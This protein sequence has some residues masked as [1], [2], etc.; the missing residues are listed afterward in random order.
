MG[1][2]HG[3]HG[4]CSSGEDM[5]IQEREVHR[6]G[7]DT[8]KNITKLCSTGQP[9]SPR[10][11]DD[12]IDDIEKGRFRYFVLKDNKKAYVEVVNGQ[13]GKFLRTNWDGTKRNNLEDLPD[14]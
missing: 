10:L 13:N 1:A 7:R 11:K 4:H 6:T 3:W 14:C 12:A 9:W 5:S 2:L 8:K